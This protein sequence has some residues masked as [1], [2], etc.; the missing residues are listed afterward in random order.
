MHVALVGPGRL[1][2]TLASLLPDAGHTVSLCGRDTPI[3]HADVVW[4][5]VPDA[6][7][8]EASARV[9]AGPIVIHAS[10]ATDLTPVAGHARHGS[11]HPLMTF[12]GPE[13]G[14]PDLHGVAAA[15]AAS[16]PATA[17]V[18]TGLAR[19]LG[20]TPVEVPGDRRLYHAAAVLAGN[21]ATVLLA[22]A[23]RILAAA[24]VPEAQG[25]ALLLPL[26]QRSLD[27]ALNDPAG[28]LTGPVA[29][30]DDAVLDAH[31]AAL[32]AAGLPE[33]AELHRVLMD[34]ARR[35]HDGSA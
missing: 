1:G 25:R 35:L 26:A 3:P 24:G 31:R 15:I 33:L 16:D 29:R 22:E 28:A 17:E 34:H 6:A 18:L 20:L 30:G 5:T 2:R 23:G 14:L 10:G 12:P 27:A 8:A 4:L 11:V 9:P 19:D 7:I 32:D 21:A 13:H